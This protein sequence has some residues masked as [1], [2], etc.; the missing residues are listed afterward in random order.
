MK[1]SRKYNAKVIITS[2]ALSNYSSPYLIPLK[3]HAATST[4]EEPTSKGVST[5]ALPAIP[6][7]RQHFGG[8]QTVGFGNGGSEDMTSAQVFLK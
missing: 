8:R 4:C 6:D 2:H 1:K 5:G 7:V 3:H